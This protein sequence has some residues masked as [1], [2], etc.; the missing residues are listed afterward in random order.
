[1][2]S[3]YEYHVVRAAK[4]FL[5]WLQECV[6]GFAHPS[7]W[8]KSV[9]QS[10]KAVQGEASRADLVLVHESLESPI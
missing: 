10:S 6:G 3:L 7:L 8:G 5:S 9:L 1:M 4:A 2:V